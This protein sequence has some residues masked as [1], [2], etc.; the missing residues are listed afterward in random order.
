MREIRIVFAQG[1]DPVVTYD[2]ADL[3]RLQRYFDGEISAAQL[4]DSVAVDYLDPSARESD[5]LARLDDVET[6]VGEPRL[7]DVL[8]P[9]MRPVARVASDFA[10]AARTA[11]DMDWLRMGAF[12]TGLV[13]ASSALDKRADQFVRDHGENRWVKAGNSFGNALP[14]LALAGAGVAALDGSD[15]ARSRTGYAALE[16]GGTA[17]LAVTG[18]KYV[19]G[20]A[21]PENELGN[22]AF[23]PFSTASG[24]DSLPSGHTIITWAVATP[25]AEEYDAPWLY[26]VAAITNLARAGSRQHWLSD[27]VA[28]S[29][30]G[31]AIGKVFWESSSAPRKGAP[32]V[33]IH[34]AGVNV[35]WA[36]N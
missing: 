22:H 31:Y 27:T 17:L 12:G 26:G 25:F 15:P 2:F 29:V 18:L 24:H 32:R 23:K 19:F 13:L 36:F 21:R 14:W 33:L 1:A 16:A 35:A 34:P 11:A 20:R 6:R 28:G 3:K 10:G 7:A 30:L 5:P 8:Q 4:A 9:V